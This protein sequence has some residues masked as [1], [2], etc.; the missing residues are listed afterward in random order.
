MSGSFNGIIDDMRIYA[1]ALTL[2][3]VSALYDEGN[4][5]KPTVPLAI[6]PK[7]S[8]SV[9]ADSVQTGGAVTLNWSTQKVTSCVASGDWSDTTELSGTRTMANLTNGDKMY[10]L[11]C[12][13]KGGVVNATVRT[14][15]AS[16][17]MP[18]TDGK[19]LMVA[20]VPTTGSEGADGRRAGGPIA[21]NFTRNLRQG[22]SGE[23]VSALQL[24]LIRFSY[25]QGGNA[26]AYFGPKTKAA[27]I[28]FQS[29]HGIPGTGFFGAMTKA[30]VIELNK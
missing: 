17:T 25:L 11:S 26:V 29:E 28:K 6:R 18:T 30:K 2:P 15:V 9:S 8:F 24:F 5:G 16:S 1:R 27:L 14:S 3:E 4:G 19:G 20:A 22:M 23:D 7:L 13:G 10:T 21:L 12:S